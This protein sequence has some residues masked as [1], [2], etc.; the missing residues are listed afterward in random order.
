MYDSCVNGQFECWTH[1]AEVYNEA[2]MKATA[3]RH[4]LSEFYLSTF[5]SAQ[6]SEYKQQLT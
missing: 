3:G 1:T 5:D 6:E 2:D 4:N